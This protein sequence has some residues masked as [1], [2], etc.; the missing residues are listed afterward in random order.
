MQPLRF[1]IVG[2]L[3]TLLITAMHLY[4]T[5]ATVTPEPGKEFTVYT[6][7]IT[8]IRND[9]DENS[10]L[11]SANQY[12]THF[13]KHQFL[14]SEKLIDIGAIN[15]NLIGD[16]RLKHYKSYF[17]PTVLAGLA[18]SQDSVS[19]V[20]KITKN[21][22][23]LPSENLRQTE[24]HSGVLFFNIL[25]WIK[26]LVFYLLLRDSQ[27][28]NPGIIFFIT[29]TVLSIYGL[30]MD[31][32][33]GRG[34]GVMAIDH[35]VPNTPRF[36]LSDS[37]QTAAFK[38]LIGATKSLIVPAPGNAIW[39]ITPRSVAT[40][41]ALAVFIAVITTSSWRFVFL[42]PVGLGVHFTTFAWQM[43]VFFILIFFSPCRPKIYRPLLIGYTFGMSGALILFQLTEILN[44]KIFCF[45]FPFIVAISYIIEFN[46]T[47]DPIKIVSLKICFISGLTIYFIVSV[48]SIFFYV[49]QFGT[50]ESKGFWIDGFTREASGR[51]A[52][53]IN[54]YLCA[55][56][57]LQ[58]I[59]KSAQIS[60]GGI[61]RIFNGVHR[62]SQKL[63]FNLTIG[64]NIL[65]ILAAHLI[66][67][68]ILI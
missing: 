31:K 21:V 56:L 20:K 42:I 52:A 29:F 6:S 61:L 5:Q 53:L 67:E 32:V 25:L 34:S 54:A 58:F 49:L 51:I 44:V 13:F 65:V 57:I 18:Y 11:P 19:E 38:A 12:Q 7:Y 33:L 35:V 15:S 1:P 10:R 14:R 17:L 48:A 4:S 37:P 24:K 64:L 16:S 63:K 45:L 46:R 62:G 30:V 43:V 3:G 22:S 47:S 68:I 50:L 40:F 36:D 9:F 39:G 66:S 28:L 2:F 41:I 59:V 8:I 60:D 27:S 23:K 26:L 55:I